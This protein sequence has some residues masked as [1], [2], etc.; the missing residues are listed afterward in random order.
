MGLFSQHLLK[1]QMLCKLVPYVI[2]YSS[3]WIY[4]PDTASSV[5]MSHLGMGWCWCMEPTE[6][7]ET[8]VLT[9]SPRNNATSN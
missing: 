8:A 3:S 1:G 7:H 9:P 5:H 4:I 2:Y 6:P